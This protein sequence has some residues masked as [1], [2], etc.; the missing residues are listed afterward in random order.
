[1]VAGVAGT[2][3]TLALASAEMW[4]GFRGNTGASVSNETGLPVEWSESQGVL[5]STPLPGASNSSPAVTSRRVY[6]TSFNADDAS[7]IVV[8][9]DRANGKILWQ[10]TV[11]RGN[12]IAY[13]PPELFRHRHNPATPSPC[14]DEHDNVYA[15]FGTGDLVSLDRDGNVR[16]QRNLAEEYGPYDLK[17][18]MGSSPRLWKDRL[19][20]AC[21][22]KGPSYV[23]ALDA[24]TGK[25]IWLADRNYVCLGDATDA[26]TTPAV[27]E[28]P[29]KAPLAVVSG[30]DHVDAYD[31]ETGRRVWENGGLVLENEEYA[32]TIASPAVGDGMVVAP[33]AK[34]KLAVAL[35]GDGAGDVTNSPEVKKVPLLSD[36]PSPTIYRGLAYSVRDD[37][38]GN[39]VDL[40][41][42]KEL[43]KS[44][45]G[46]E[47]YQASP[48]AGDGKVYFLSLEGKCTVIE[49]GPAFNVLSENVIPGEYYATPAISDRVIFLR[50]RSHIVAVAQHA[51]SAAAKF[52]YDY[53]PDPSFPQW[54]ADVT[55]GP[56]SGVGVDRQGR[57]I[58]L[59]RE[60]PP[61]LVFEADGKFVTSFG[62]EV[63]GS[64]HGLTVDGD[65]NI[66]V[67]DTVHH[68]VF[69]FSPQGKILKVLGKMDAPSEDADKFNKPTYIVFG[70]K[71]DLYVMDGYGNA[72]V[73][74]Y[75]PGG[76]HPEIWGR[77]G[78]GP[79][80]FNAPH[81][82]VI[83]LQGRLVVADRDNNRIQILHPQTGELME[84]WTG[85][86]PFG[87]AQDRAGTIFISDAKRQ[88]II[89]LDPR[90]R[91][92]RAWGKDGTGPGEFKTPHL[93]TAD[94]EGNLY[95]A[96]V[97][98]RRVQKLKRVR[99]SS[100]GS[101]T[102]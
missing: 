25:E 13:G 35:P 55:L 51:G 57:V 61:V 48:V 17:F 41:T 73:V 6:V 14:A 88:Q 3:I 47:R 31:L 79:L 46:G 44:R 60:K 15:F 99:L 72:R 96:E 24:A 86:T 69:Q 22:H 84:T 49:A 33:S 102:E 37:G 28:I 98:G 19:I 78:S 65:D 70:A 95:A 38:V 4:S 92:V 45:I 16:W 66:W 62:D 58:V 71:G 39:C 97:A 40:K 81:A 90:G 26:Y 80:E 30:A 76:K 29:G 7:L 59:Q 75:R 2:L 21:V 94:G 74:H 32:R 11:G 8:A 36:C 68:V 67:T 52:D 34:A 20:V 54:P 56:V 10:K 53:Q 63:I 77:P 1:M 42:G 101:Q 18:G 100:G 87:I 89:Q 50:S 91:E 27:L 64:G 83:D 5:W 9:L 85:Y 12:L 82:A 93:I 23:V 43:W